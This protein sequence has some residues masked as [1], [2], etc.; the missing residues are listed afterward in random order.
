MA[1]YFCRHFNV[2]SEPESEL[3]IIEGVRQARGSC[4]LSPNWET[5]T[6]LH[7]CS[8]FSP[9]EAGLIGRW[10]VAMQEAYPKLRDE[11]QQRKAT[12]KKLKELRATTRAQKAV[13]LKVVR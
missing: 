5:V 2:T 10:W 4:T 13:T 9:R 7:Y 3:G 6:G 8:L 12:E 1:C 11:H